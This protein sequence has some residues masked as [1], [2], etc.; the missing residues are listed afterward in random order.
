MTTVSNI[1]P[2][3]QWNAD[4]VTREGLHVH[5]RPV[6]ADD[7]PALAKFFAHVTPEDLRFRFL[8]GLRVV[9]HA[10]LHQMVE[11]DYV[12]TV[13]FLAFLDDEQTIVATATLAADKE[14]K[15]AEIALST[16]AD[17]K[18]RGISWLL[19]EHVVRFAE[20]KGIETVEA[21]EAADHEEA[22]QMEREMGFEV[23]ECPGDPSLRIVRRTLK[24]PS[25]EAAA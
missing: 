18:H 8:S 9:D 1:D 22:L 23:R 14:Q 20:A 19:F 6:M 2:L 12:Q 4:L 5:V 25:R 16:R 13:T 21:L 24:A 3:L 10:R 17:M 11:I 7:E 15:S